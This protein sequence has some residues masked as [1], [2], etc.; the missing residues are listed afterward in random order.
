M[1][2]GWAGSANEVKPAASQA[3]RLPVSTVAACT[4][5]G[6]NAGSAAAP[7]TSAPAAMPDTPSPLVIVRRPSLPRKAPSAIRSHS[8]AMDALAPSPAGAAKS[9]VLSALYRMPFQAVKMPPMLPDGSVETMAE[10]LVYRESTQAGT[11]AN[12]SGST[13]TPSIPSG[14]RR[15]FVSPSSKSMPLCEL[16]CSF[17][18]LTS[19][20][21]RS[22]NAAKN[23]GSIVVTDAGIAMLAIPGHAKRAAN[24]SA[25][26]AVAAAVSVGSVPT[27][28]G[29]AA[30]GTRFSVTPPR[31]KSR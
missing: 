19:T 11:V 23:A 9:S 5:S 25:F 15:R 2:P 17:C 6:S 13:A 20:E 31:S 30:S 24:A 18:S 21:R 16:K 28:C 26:A 8:R 3:L 1:S 14:T 12:V 10:S 22:G 4:T 29:S 7:S 27:G